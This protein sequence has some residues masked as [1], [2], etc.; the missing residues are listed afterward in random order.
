MSIVQSLLVAILALELLIYVI[1]SSSKGIREKIKNKGITLYPF[2]FLIDLGKM[3]RIKLKKGMKGVLYLLVMLGA[4][5]FVF[6][7]YMF[8]STLIPSILSFLNTL[9]KGGG[10]V[11]SPFIPIVPGIT[12]GLEQFIYIVLALSVGI[13]LHE[14]FHALAAYLAGWRVESWGLGLFFIFPLAY[15][16]P[17]EEDYNK[18]GLKSKTAVLTAGVLANTMLFLIAMVLIP[19]AFS[20]INTA[21]VIISLDY[22]DVTAPAVK[23]SIPAPSILIAINDTEVSSVKD[24]RNFLMSYANMSVTY[25][26]KLRKARIVG[27]VVKPVSD[28]IKFVLHKPKGRWRL[29]II[30]SELPLEGVS[31]L[32]IKISRFLYWFYIVNISLAVINAA[33]LYITDGGRLVSELLKKLKLEFLN[34]LVQG[35]T[36]FFVIT[37]LVI[38]LLKFL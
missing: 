4:A 1:V 5:N 11:V 27:D 31:P 7:L 12:V 37:F 20:Q 33:P 34:H 36:V 35:I 2:L 18:A 23:A 8:Y 25:V 32:L 13:A 9:T 10:E 24:L 29:G 28:I 6:L 38:G 26:V 15:V 17:N 14:I 21:V 3:P 19:L 22:N 30:V 16:R